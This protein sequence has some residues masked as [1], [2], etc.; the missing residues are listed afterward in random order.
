M[1][2]S[3]FGDRLYGGTVG[4]SYHD[5]LVHAGCDDAAAGRYRAWQEYS[6]EDLLALDAELIVTSTGQ[7]IA[8]RRRPGADRLRARI[9]ELP[10]AVAGDP[11]LGMVDA[12]E[13]LRA[14]LER[15]P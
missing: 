11:G 14:A 1:W 3:I 6:L 5:L 13:A 8:L 12:V 10:E 15:K 7:G 4:S 2:V 9:I